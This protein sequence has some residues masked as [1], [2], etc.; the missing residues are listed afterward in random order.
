M[1]TLYTWEDNGEKKQIQL[2]TS[3]K[4]IQTSKS[5]RISLEEDKKKTPNF[6]DINNTINLEY[7]IF[8]K[9]TYIDV[10]IRN[11]SFHHPITRILH[12]RKWYNE[13]NIEHEKPDQGNQHY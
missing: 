9:P 8:R 10:V 7:N 13:W 2:N 6:L 12:P 11:A 5:N 1:F 4:F 3:T